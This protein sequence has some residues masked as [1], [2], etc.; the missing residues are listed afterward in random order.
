MK[1]EEKDITE[2]LILAAI[3]D[4]KIKSEEAASEEMKNMTGG[5]SLPPGFKLPF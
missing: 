5:I 2:D 4:A 3:N 1:P